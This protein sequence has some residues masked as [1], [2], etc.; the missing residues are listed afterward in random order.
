M[1]F[2]NFAKKTGTRFLISNGEGEL[3]VM[4][5]NAYKQREKQLELREKLFEIEEVRRLGVQDIPARSASTSLRER[6]LGKD[7]V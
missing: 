4:D 5:I 2:L 7:N 6:V 3:V 1:I